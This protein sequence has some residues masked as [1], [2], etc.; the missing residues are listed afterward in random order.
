MEFNIKKVKE[1]NYGISVLRVILSF[2]VVMD[3]FYNKKRKIKFIH[4][5]YYHIP[6]FFLISFFYTHK[7]FTSYNIEKIKLRFQRLVIPYISWSIISF[8]LYNIYYYIFKINC[9]HNLSDFFENLLNG[10]VFIL[11]LWFQNILIFTTLI[12]SIVILLFR[13]EYLLILLIFIMISYAC[14]YSGINYNFFFLN[15]TS[16]YSATYGRFLDTFPSFLSGFFI[17]EFKIMNKQRKYFQIII[18][19][20]CMI[21]L[22]FISIYKFNYK[23]LTFK[24][25]GIRLNTAAICIFLIFFNLPF[26]IIRNIKMKNI[27]DKI[28]NYTAGIYF[29]HFLIGKGIIMKII[30]G[31]K[32]ETVFGCFIIYLISYFS[33]F[34][35]DKLIGNTKLKH[36]IK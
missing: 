26:N 9:R 20:I 7:T 22:I 33:C 24:Y 11:A 14:Q 15:F 18:I 5:L 8:I 16:L 29:I 27:L 4:I 13:N 21:I 25:G 19:I 36:L 1:K 34:L 12:M 28:T 23:L 30:L 3:H 6:T 17:A 31:N 10:H 2:M 32:I 35:L